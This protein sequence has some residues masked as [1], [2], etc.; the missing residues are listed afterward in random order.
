MVFAG[1]VVAIM[2]FGWGDKMLFGAFGGKFKH[3]MIKILICTIKEVVL[4]VVE[5]RKSEHLL[6]RG[7]CCLGEVDC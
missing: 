7:K 4:L 3:C 6:F 2:S 5:I 1:K